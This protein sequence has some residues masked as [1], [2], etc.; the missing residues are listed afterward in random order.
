MKIIT[1]NRLLDGV[2]V[3]RSAAGDW[4]ERFA[5]AARYQDAAAPAALAEAERDV[6][7]VVKPYL[8]ALDAPSEFTKRERVREAIRAAGP[9]VRP[10]LG[11][12]AEGK[13]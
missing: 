2:V 13:S 10:D 9:T 8:V 5:E 7:A 12:Q 1:A 11:K 3:Y 6:L 4:V